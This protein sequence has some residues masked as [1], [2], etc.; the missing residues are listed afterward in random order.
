LAWAWKELYEARK[1][2]QVL[3]RVI[4]LDRQKEEAPRKKVMEEA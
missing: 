1:D 3:T 2:N 4:A